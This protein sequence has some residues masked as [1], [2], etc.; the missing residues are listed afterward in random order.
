MNVEKDVV[1]DETERK[2]KF[3][4]LLEKI[5]K[6]FNVKDRKRIIRNFIEKQQ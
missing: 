5:C 1:L 6:D 4:N 3:R 2:E